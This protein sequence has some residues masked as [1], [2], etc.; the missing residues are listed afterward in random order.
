MSIIL[1]LILVP[2]SHFWVKVAY[3]SVW[4]KVVFKLLVPVKIAPCVDG[5]AC[6]EMLS[7][8]SHVLLWLLWVGAAQHMHAD[9]STPIVDCTVRTAHLG[10]LFH[11]SIK[12]LAALHVQP[13]LN[14]SPPRSPS[15]VF[16]NIFR[17]EVLHALFQMKSVST[18]RAM[19]LFLLHAFPRGQN[20]CTTEAEGGAHFSSNHFTHGWWGGVEVPSICQFPSLGDASNVMSK[21]G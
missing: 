20:L 13:S 11:V 1:F 21:L 8:M 7:S 2:G 6:I 17:D 10:F 4:S 15:T 9:F 12:L 19:E 16:D 5:S 18:G 14:W 3:C